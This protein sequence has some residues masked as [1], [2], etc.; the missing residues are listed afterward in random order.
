MIWNYVHYFSFLPLTLLNLPLLKPTPGLQA[1]ITTLSPPLL[2][3]EVRTSSH[4]YHCASLATESS[5]AP[6]LLEPTLPRVGVGCPQ[7][8][9]QSGRGC[10]VF[11]VRGWS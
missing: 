6:A 3:K 9:A 11:V 1:G 2:P 5:T 10:G 8:G 4:Y 7:G